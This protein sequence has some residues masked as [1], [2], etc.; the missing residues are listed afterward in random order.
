VWIVDI[1][2]TYIYFTFTL[3]KMVIYDTWHKLWLHIT[4]FIKEHMSHFMSR[5]TY[6]HFC[7]GTHFTIY[8]KDYISPFL[9]RN[10]CHNLC[11]GLHITIFVKEHISQ[12]FTF[13]WIRNFNHLT[14]VDCWYIFNLY[15]FYLYLD[16]NGDI[17]YLT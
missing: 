14:C 2:L 16:K 17:R 5:I 7:Q 6:H 9:S 10:T 15:I 1:F 3:T 4:I 12:F 8:V 13:R 11:Q